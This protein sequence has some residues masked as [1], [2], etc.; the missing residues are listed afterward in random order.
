MT[1]DEKP[2]ANV[3][4][5]E[6]T[7]IRWLAKRTFEVDL[8]RPSSFH[9]AAG[10]RLRLLHG[11]LERDYSIVSAPTDDVL[12]LCVRKVEEGLFSPILAN[13][14]PGARF[15]FT[16]PHGYFIYHKS[17]YPTVFVATGTGVAPFASMARSGVTGFALL[18]GA[19]RQEDLYYQ[20]LFRGAA[21]LYAPCLSD[22]PPD[23]S[24]PP[25]AFYG[26]VT[27]YLQ[28][29]FPPVPHEFYLC[30]RGEMIRDATLL[31]DDRFAESLVH[32][33]IYY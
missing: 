7:G 30:G 6:L 9:F 14:E 1:V 17:E 16:G 32:T 20:P 8:A 11:D 19:R 21:G 33:E 15:Y 18:H 31:I 10:Q 25:D 12:T 22:W 28:K 2:E 13:A 29:Y 3:Y 4:E 24:D 27:G 5:G 26:R 23:P